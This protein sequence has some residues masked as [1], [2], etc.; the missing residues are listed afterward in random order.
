VYTQVFKFASPF[1][2]Y[3]RQANSTHCSHTQTCVAHLKNNNM[4]HWPAGLTAGWRASWLGVT[5]GWR[6]SRPAARFH[7]QLEGFT[8]CQASWGVASPAVA[9]KPLG[10]SRPAGQFHGQLAGWLCCSH[11]AAVKP[12]GVS[13]LAGW[14]HSRQPTSWRA[15]QPA[16]S[17]LTATWLD[18]SPNRP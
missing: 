2:N 7:G 13:R 16:H 11:A 15:A 14:F 3:S 18:Y 17:G 9:V 6:V 12:L 10:V 8:A 5:A 1:A 4:H